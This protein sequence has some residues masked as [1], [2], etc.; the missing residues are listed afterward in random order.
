MWITIIGCVLWAVV[1]AVSARL[2][3]IG[4]HAVEWS[5]GRRVAWCVLLLLAA[6]LFMRPHEDIFGGQDTGAYLTG[7]AVFAREGALSYTDPL[8]SQLPEDERAPFVT[9]KHYTA[10]YHCLWLPDF[11]EST[12]LTWFQPAYPVMAG[13]PTHIL[14]PISVL[15]V[16]PLLAILTGLA[17]R[18]LASRLFDHPWAGEAAFLCYVLNPLVVWH[19]RYP[20]PEVIASFMLMGG[21]ALLLS[22]WNRPRG[23]AWGDLLLGALC[24][25]LAPFFHVS[26]WTM[27]LVVALLVVAA[28]ASGRDDFLAALAIAGGTFLLFL[29]EIFHI[30]DTYRLTR[31]VLPFLP[32]W[33][34]LV[35]VGL[36]LALLL[37]GVSWF[38]RGR[39]WSAKPRWGLAARVGGAALILGAF[40]VVAWFAYHTTVDEL[41]MYITR[42]LWRTDLRCVVEMVSLPIALL[43]LAGV[44]V[45]ALRSGRGTAGRWGV[46]VALVPAALVVGNFY[47]FFLTR[48]MLVV[49][50]PLLVLGVT[51][52]V[53]LIPATGAKGTRV[54]AVAL[55]LGCLLGV[56][57]RSL[58]IRH[59]QF[60]G[61]V[62]YMAE[63]AE[64]VKQADGMVLF[65]YPQLAAP[66]D[67]F[68]GVPTLPLNNERLL[69][70]ANAET[71]WSGLMQ[72]NAG[73]R[74]FFITPYE[75]PPASDRFVFVPQ[76]TR[77]YSGQRIMAYRWALPTEVAD[78][79]CGLRMYEMFPVSE[80]TS[81]G[82]EQPLPWGGHFGYGNMGLRGFESPRANPTPQ[83]PCV[84]L[85]PEAPLS[86]AL[87]ETNSVTGDVLMIVCSD[88]SGADPTIRLEH[89]GTALAGNLQ[90]LV[91]DW[92]L[93]RAEAPVGGT[94]NVFGDE[95]TWLSVARRVSGNQI[96]PVFD[97][98]ESP[99]HE[100]HAVT[101]FDSRWANSNSR[102]QIPVPV[103]GGACL[104]TFVL[105]P[106]EWGDYAL[107]H[108]RSGKEQQRRVPAGKFVWNVWS[109]GVAADGLRTVPVA[110]ES[111]AAQPADGTNDV[112]VMPV[113][114][115]YAA[116]VE[117]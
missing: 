11:P 27:V 58:L 37:Y 38:V 62:N 31:F 88:L 41:K 66:L 108:V 18:A 103:S 101:P 29:Y 44:L 63:V 30:T 113:A 7:S 60:K 84:R 33:P 49:I 73:K 53:T 95:R 87:G 65:E 45:M 55:A 50:V 72:R 76:G 85:H 36:G 91:N 12:M 57:N 24:L 10:K 43:G 96:H 80:D 34:L 20:R 86:I 71:T 13:L 69:D 52:L 90:H 32:H 112:A 117:Q 26:A 22:A 3:V 17:L 106:H 19:A 23:R 97:A 107:L 111:R 28:V 25:N 5:T 56:H 47:D 99:K 46:L 92:W 35:G 15:Y 68:F 115:G 89:N 102:F 105:A 82:T 79:G 2:W 1:I 75:R 110:V 78:W 74:A 104:L 70:Y 8:L 6:I 40:L 59:V 67:L 77:E 114:L 64:E 94:L 83:T 16:I 61:F 48:Y 54:F 81:A 9:A 4:G 98:W 100:Q 42:F 109:A 116:V 21:L 93:Y 39:N 51:S 14:P